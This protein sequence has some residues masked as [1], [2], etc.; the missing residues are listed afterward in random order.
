MI[1]II[2]DCAAKLGRTPR[3]AELEEIGQNQGR[4]DVH[5]AFGALDEHAL[6]VCGL[7]DEKEQ[8][9]VRSRRRY[10]WS[11]RGLSGGSE[12]F[13]PLQSTRG[14][15]GRSLR[16]L[17]SRFRSWRKVPIGILEYLR[18]Q[19]LQG[20]WTDAAAHYSCNSSEGPDEGEAGHQAMRRI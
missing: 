19:G 13:R 4:Y 15:S 1:A 16:P 2:K 10:F 12:R 5:K 3:L 20:G 8:G 18:N 9:I 14:S 11:G 6:E 17:V 7:E